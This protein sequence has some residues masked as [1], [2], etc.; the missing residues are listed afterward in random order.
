MAGLMFRAERKVTA[1]R[2]KHHL[3]A[4]RITDSLT[5]RRRCLFCGCS[6]LWPYPFEPPGQDSG[7]P[8]GS[9]LPGFADGASFSRA[10]L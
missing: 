9:R 7:A 6:A 2:I 10:W 3:H 4:N 8:P 1:I 5:P